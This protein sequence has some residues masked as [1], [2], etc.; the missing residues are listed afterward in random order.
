V[1]D[2]PLLSWVALYTAMLLDVAQVFAVDFSDGFRNP[3]LGAR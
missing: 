1:S 3:V 2:R